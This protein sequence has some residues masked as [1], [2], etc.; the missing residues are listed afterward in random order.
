[1]GSPISHTVA[2]L[3]M[4]EI[5]TKAI[6]TA[7]NPPKLWL[8]YEDDTFVIQWAEHSNQLLQLINSIDPHIQFT[9]ETSNTDGSIPF[10]HILVSPGLGNTLILQ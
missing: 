7:T 9:K 4:E 10:L 8:M 6:N 2:N 1:M 5:E 3:F